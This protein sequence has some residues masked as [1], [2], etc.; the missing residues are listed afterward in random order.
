MQKG[1]NR[2]KEVVGQDTGELS[3]LQTTAFKNSALSLSVSM[4]IK[5]LQRVQFDLF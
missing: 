3:Q 2:A 4:A 5:G 1:E